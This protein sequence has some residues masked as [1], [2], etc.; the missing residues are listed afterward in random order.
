MDSTL[1]RR[2]IL[3]A[4]EPPEGDVKTTTKNRLLMMERRH[5]GIPADSTETDEKCT[6]EQKR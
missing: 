3:A 6:D 4:I 1:L 5:L 2:V